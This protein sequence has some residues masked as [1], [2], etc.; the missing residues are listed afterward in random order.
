V[1][2]LICMSCGSRISDDEATYYGE[3]CE[4]CARRDWERVLRW[5]AGAQDA[6]LD[7]RYSDKPTVH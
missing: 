3:R 2:I 5:K 1:T 4:A 7:A 6:E